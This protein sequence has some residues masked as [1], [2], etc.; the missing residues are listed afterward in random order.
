M[1]MTNW[2]FA[3]AI[4]ENEEFKINQMNIWNFQWHCL[5]KKVEV[6]GPYEGQV[7]YFKHYEITDGTQKIEFVA[8]EFVNSKVG[9]YIKDDLCD[10]K[11]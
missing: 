11:I 1:I 10:K 8:G 2:K 5:N 7:Y 6:L 9:I 3:K 4:D